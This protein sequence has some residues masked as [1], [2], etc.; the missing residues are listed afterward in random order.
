MS[1]VYHFIFLFLFRTF[2]YR[3][4]NHIYSQEANLE[5]T[6]TFSFRHPSHES[7]VLILY[8]ELKKKKY[9]CEQANSIGIT[10]LPFFSLTSQS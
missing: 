1:N 5:Q 7:I 9:V 4:E 8:Y 3:S 2:G 6:P 10:G